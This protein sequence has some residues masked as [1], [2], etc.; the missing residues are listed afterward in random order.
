MLVIDTSVVVKWYIRDEVDADH[1]LALMDRGD[2]HAPDLLRIEL[3]NALIRRMRRS[4]ALPVP[5]GR[6]AI[7]AFQQVPI[8]Y[9][10][11]GGLVETI[12]DLALMYQRHP[13]DC[14]FLALALSLR[15]PMV[16]AD[17]AFVHGMEDT[18]FHDVIRPLNDPWL[19]R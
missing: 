17:M 1:A 9:H 11:I 2:L 4:Q 5:Y 7:T 19:R 3:V 8:A 10:P 6:Q 16:T 15:C 18:T 14:A 13:Y 12:T